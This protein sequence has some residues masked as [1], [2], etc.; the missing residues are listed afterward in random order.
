MTNP[1]GG[2]QMAM[3]E[4]ISKLRSRVGD[5]ELILVAASV[6][7]FDDQNRILLHHRTDNDKWGIPGGY[8]NPGESVEQAARREVMEETGL[9]LGKLE[10]FGIYSGEERRVKLP[11]GHQIANV[12]IVFSCREYE[13]N[14]SSDNWDGESKDVRFFA[15]DE[16]PDHFYE[17][18]RH[19]LIDLMSGGTPPFIR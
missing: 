7:I 3:G 18:Q 19:S 8:I 13:G 6:L 9:T 4:Y 15:L 2:T 12:K 17:S 16:I 11:N 1:T 10:L 14:L 5:M